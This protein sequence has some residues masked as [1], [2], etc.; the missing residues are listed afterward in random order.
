MLPFFFF[1]YCSTASLK[2]YNILISLYFEFFIKDSHSAFKVVIMNTKK[3]KNLRIDI[4]P[5]LDI[6][7]TNP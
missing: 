7:F 1:F 5:L 3:H 4:Y 2:F 6:L